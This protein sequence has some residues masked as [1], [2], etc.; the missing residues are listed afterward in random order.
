QR[1][2]YRMR[3]NSRWLLNTIPSRLAYGPEGIFGGGDGAKGTFQI[4]GEDVADTRKREMNPDDE[5][6]MITPGGGGY[7]KA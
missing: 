3:T 2:G 6:F 1:I 4:N 5:V 7:G